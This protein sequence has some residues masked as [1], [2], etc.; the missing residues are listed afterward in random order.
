MSNGGADKA[1]KTPQCCQPHTPPL[2]LF[3]YLY[4]IQVEIEGLT[5]DIKFND[6]GRR[7]N[8]T[9]HVVEMTVN[10]AMVSKRIREHSSH[11]V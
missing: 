4:V 9:L 3:V 10:S 11:S 1:I 6:D 8:Y 5:G 2:S 7:V